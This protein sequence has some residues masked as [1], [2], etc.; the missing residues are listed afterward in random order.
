MTSWVPALGGQ[1]GH[2]PTLEIMWMGIAHPEFPSLERVWVTTAHPGFC[3]KTVL[4]YDK[5]T[6]LVLG[7]V[8]WVGNDA[9]LPTQNTISRVGKFERRGGKLK[10]N[11]RY[12]AES[13]LAHPLQKSCRRPCMTYKYSGDI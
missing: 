9:V 11:W 12:S 4:Y 7:L 3:A 2:V 5:Y 1:G 8:I 13:F 10:T 6:I